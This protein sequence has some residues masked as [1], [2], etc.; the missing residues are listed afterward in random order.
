VSRGDRNAAAFDVAD[1]AAAKAA[2][3]KA[4]DVFGGQMVGRLVD[5]DVEPCRRR[6]SEEVERD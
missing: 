3:S 5:R 2:V 6:R 4:C 1:E